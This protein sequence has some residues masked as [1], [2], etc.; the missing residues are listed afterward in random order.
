MGWEGRRGLGGGLPGAI[1]G[2]GVLMVVM[3][4][5]SARGEDSLH[6][7]GGP[8]GGK[9][10]SCRHGFNTLSSPPFL[11][12]DALCT[13]AKVQPLRAPNVLHATPLAPSGAAL[14][15]KEPYNC[16]DRP[17]TRRDPTAGGFGM[18]AAQGEG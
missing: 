6:C 13:H 5:R 11:I 2:V 16:S 4:D 18:A 14:G 3:E 8:R 17:W 10:C 1:R 7:M 12:I 9:N 15:P